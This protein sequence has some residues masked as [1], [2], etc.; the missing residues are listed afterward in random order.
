MRTNNT[1]T[2][3]ANHARLGSVQ[4]AARKVFS[5]PVFM[6]T[7]LSAGAVAATVWDKAPIVAGKIFAEGDTWWHIVVG[8][9]ILTTHTWP[10]V[11]IY[12]FTA[13]GAGWIASEWLGEVILALAAR[14]GGLSGLAVLLVVLSITYFLLMF[15]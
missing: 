14:L 15:Y 3:T 12:S 7:V 6:G 9:R 2:A 11:D 13:H 4:G 1:E 10:T 8:E 5:F